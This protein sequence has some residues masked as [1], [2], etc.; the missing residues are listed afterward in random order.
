MQ[1]YK[2]II[3]ID[4]SKDDLDIFTLDSLGNQNYEKCKNLSSSIINWLETIDK[5]NTLCVLEPTGSY[6]FHIM[7]YLS[8]YEISFSLVNP[9]QS[10]GFTKA[11]GIVSKN[12]RQASLSLAM[13]G[14]SLDLPLY[15]YPVSDMLKR[16][17]ILLGLN[18]LKKQERMLK[19][20]LHALA[21][22]IIFSQK[23]VSALE[24]TLET[25]EQQIQ[26]LEEELND[27]SDDES[28]KQLKLMKSV[29]GI[30]PK[31]SQLLLVATGGLQNFERS[32]QL[33][34]FIGLIPSSHYSGSSVRRTGRITKKGNAPLR[35][36]LYMAARSARKYNLAC[37]DLY[38]RL[39]FKGKP[40]KQAMVAV[41]NKLV[42]QIFGVVQSG[43]S[44][45]NQYYLKFIEK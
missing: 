2:N 16:K 4:V 45:D 35:A 43:I 13:M 33:S 30:G 27:L 15:K 25:V 26:S 11:Q 23:V 38:D 41:M 17:Q 19:N 36:S 34:K 40:H 21:H 5:K 9:N 32:D 28:E 42:K 12:D 1:K 29:K 6:S 39:R 37:K 31:T 44:F 24:S 18:A 22:Q 3:G 20:Q 7:H 14:R 10:A 8:H